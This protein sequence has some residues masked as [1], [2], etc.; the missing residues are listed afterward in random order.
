MTTARTPRVHDNVVRPWLG[1]CRSTLTTA[2]TPTVHDV[3]LDSVTAYWQRQGHQRYMMLCL[4][5]SQHIDNGKDTKGTWCYAWQCHSILTTARTP[6]VHD[7]M[8]DSVT[9][10]WQRQG[11]QRYMMLSLTVS[12][13]TDNGK[14]TNGTWCYAW[15]SHSILTTARTPTVHHNVMLWWCHSI[16]TTA[17]TSRVHHN[18]VR[19][20]L[21]LC[22]STLTTARTPRVHHNVVRPWLGL[23]QSTL[24]TARTS[25]VHH[26]VVRRW[27][28]DGEGERRVGVGEGPKILLRS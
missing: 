16:L 5:V 15:Q 8:L 28:V 19:P 24:T 10:Y 27:L 26:N 4:I 11:H 18:V 9:A 12:Q 7:V 23:C 3:T 2:R 13:H 1:L 25:R 20:W 6:T 17:R 21:G 22:Q 14:D